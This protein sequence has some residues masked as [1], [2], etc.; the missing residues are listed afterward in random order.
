MAFANSGD[1]N[2]TPKQGDFGEFPEGSYQMV[3]IEDYFS[4]DDSDIPLPVFKPVQ[5]E[6]KAHCHFRITVDM[7]QLPAW[8]GTVQD[9]VRLATAFGA[10]LTAIKAEPTTKFLFAIQ[11]SINAVSPNTTIFV[12]KK[13]WVQ[14]INAL[15]PPTNIYQLAFINAFSVDKSKPITFQDKEFNFS[16]RIEVHQIVKFQFEIVSDLQ[17]NDQYVGTR[18][19]INVF[20]PFD[21]PKNGAPAFHVHKNG[22]MLKSERRIRTFANI[23][24][25]D[26]VDG[27]TWQADPEKSAYGIN[28]VENPVVVITEKAKESGRRAVA[29]VEIDDRGFFKMD[30]LDLVPGKSAPVNVKPLTPPTVT[31]NIPVHLTL[32]K[33]VNDHAFPDIGENALISGPEGPYGLSSKGGTW[34]KEHLVPLWDDLKLPVT[35]EGKHDF[36]LLSREQAAQLVNSLDKKLGSSTF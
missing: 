27:Y 13:G 15:L 14:K 33:T 17:D 35:P 25:V 31:G 5:N 4:T 6:L 3:G 36:S 23:F 1:P 16:G 19:T 2:I 11:N 12:N 18:F 21:A 7:A 8:S 30:L 22:G 24:W 9:Y 28:E 26:D 20:N 32:I 10:D 34:C 29:K